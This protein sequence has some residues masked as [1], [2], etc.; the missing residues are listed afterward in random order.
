MVYKHLEPNKAFLSIL[1]VLSAC[2][3]SLNSSRCCK[4]NEVIL[5][6]QVAPVLQSIV[7]AYDCNLVEGVF[8]HEIKQFVIDGNKCVLNKP[9]PEAK[10]AEGT[11]EENEVYAVDIVV[12]TGEGKTRIIDEKETTVSFFLVLPLFPFLAPPDAALASR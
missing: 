2:L 12:S 6:R 10:V 4:F 5:S 3:A 9:S 1:N 11:F 7:E 8:T